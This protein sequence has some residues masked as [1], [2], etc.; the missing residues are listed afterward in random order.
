MG[1]C[2]EL[3]Q[4]PLAQQGLQGEPLGHLYVVKIDF[5][6]HFSIE[7]I[8]ILGFGTGLKRIRYWKN[9]N[10]NDDFKLEISLLR[11][12]MIFPESDKISKITKIRI[13]PCIL[14]NA[15]ATKIFSRSNIPK[16]CT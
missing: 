7:V 12:K 2:V 6:R 11:L 8:I 13:N 1:V 5:N 14:L 10:F 3:D 4:P 15:F 9:R 16:K